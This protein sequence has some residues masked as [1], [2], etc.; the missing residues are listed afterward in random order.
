MGS[1]LSTAPILF[2]LAVRWLKAQVVALRPVVDS[3]DDEVTLVVTLMDL[4]LLSDRVE[5]AALLAA[6]AKDFASFPK[7]IKMPF[8]L[9]EGVLLREPRRLTAP[10]TCALP[11]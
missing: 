9:S 4:T 8:E 6:V 5:F 1:L 11:K 10:Y 2:V 3:K 7:P